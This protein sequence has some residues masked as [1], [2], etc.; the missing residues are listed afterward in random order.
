MFSPFYN[1]VNGKKKTNII[2]NIIYFSGETENNDETDND[3][4]SQI[5][6]LEDKEISKFC[7][8]FFITLLFSRK[9]ALNLAHCCQNIFRRQ[10]NLYSIKQALRENNAILG[11]LCIQKQRKSKNRA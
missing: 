1:F 6:R 8:K 7:L 9:I 4:E 11:K 3:I 5:R 2:N 10:N